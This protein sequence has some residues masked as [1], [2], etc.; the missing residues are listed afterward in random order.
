MK[1]VNILKR[2]KEEKYMVKLSK[3]SQISKLEKTAAY[4][5]RAADKYWAL[6][7]NGHG[8]ENYGYARER[9][10]RAAKL[11]EMAEKLKK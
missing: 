10:E 7:K 4:F 1:S 11:I 5:K 8:G 6:A 3:E 9:Y 2:S